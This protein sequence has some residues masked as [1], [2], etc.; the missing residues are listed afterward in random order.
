[1]K[2]T[3][4]LFF[5]VGF[6]LYGEEKY[7]GL[8][9]PERD[10]V[11]K[12]FSVYEDERAR[13]SYDL[14]KIKNCKSVSFLMRLLDDELPTWCRYNGYGL[15]TSPAKEA[16]ETIIKIGE[17]SLDYIFQ[18]LEDKHPYV[19]LNKFNEK[20][21]IYVLEKITGKNYKDIN[22]WIIWWQEQQG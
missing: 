20:N 9:P 6:L 18:V 10:Y 8:K 1:M 13:G 2:K 19:K 15:W 5:L 11:Y 4:L 12:T 17:P 21:L 16:R 22:E 14:S 7:K 3:F